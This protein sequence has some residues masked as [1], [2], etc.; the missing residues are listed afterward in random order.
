MSMNEIVDILMTADEIEV[1]EMFVKFWKLMDV[2]P[3]GTTSAGEI[4]VTAD[5]MNHFDLDG[6]LK[7]LKVF[8]GEIIFSE[9]IEASAWWKGEQA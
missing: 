3:N 6:F 7:F 2:D 5:D 9:E 8:L 4:D 1:A